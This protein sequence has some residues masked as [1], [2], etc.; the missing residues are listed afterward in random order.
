MIKIGVLIP[1]RGD[2]KQLLDFALKQI[3][4]QIQQPQEIEVVNDAPV[5]DKPDITWRYRIGCERLVKK[6]C[7][8]I[9][10]W[11]DDD[12][13]RKDYIN[14]M[15]NKWIELGYP[16]LIGLNHTIYYNI[17][18]Q[19]YLKMFHNTHASMMSTCISAAGVKKLNWGDD[20][21]SFTDTIIWKQLKSK[22][23]WTSKEEICV[24]IKHGIGLCGGGGH[25]PKFGH[26]RLQDTN[27]EHLSTLVSR[28]AL[29]FYKQISMKSKYLIEKNSFLKSPF[30]T[31]VTRRMVKRSE[32][33]YKKHTESKNAL[34]LDKENI[35]IVD[36]KKLGML[37]ANSSFSFVTDK[38]N[39]Q[40]IHLLDDDDFYTNPKFIEIL[41]STALKHNYPDVI[42]FKM[43]ILTGDGDQIYPK[44]ASWNTGMIGRAQIGGSCFVVRKWVYEKY[45]H[46]FAYKSFGDWNFITEVMKDKAVRSAWVNEIMCETGK[47]SRGE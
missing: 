31:I 30:L 13:Y 24:G 41:K 32:E 47:V 6:G 19:Q 43:K 2:R 22:S 38:I 46:N 37:N 3:Q 12:F 11:E 9:V 39:G 25:S 33:L 4:Q 27:H 16:D 36:T 44:P 40:Y 20:N 35:F 42:F 14:A 28:E 21:Y 17:F 45:I 26:Y 29:C 7:N 5:S 18:T 10:F 1:T 23:L 8:F 15:L 34:S